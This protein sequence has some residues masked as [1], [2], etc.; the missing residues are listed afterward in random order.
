MIF[1]N[2]D[3]ENVQPTNPLLLLN[4]DLAVAP[5]SLALLGIMVL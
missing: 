5:L 1:F 2:I 3:L 4:T